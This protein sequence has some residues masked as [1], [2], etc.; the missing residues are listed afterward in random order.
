MPSTLPPAAFA[1]EDEAQL[2]NR[3][4]RTGEVTEP[5]GFHQD[6]DRIQRLSAQSAFP[7]A[8]PKAFKKTS[9]VCGLF[10]F[11]VPCSLGTNILARSAPIQ[12]TACA[13]TFISN[14][15]FKGRGEPEMFTSIFTVALAAVAIPLLSQS[16]TQEPLGTDPVVALDYGS[17]EGVSSNGISSFFGIPYAAPP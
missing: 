13:L 11:D 9:A 16:L 4:K 5:Y 12:S 2:T 14:L 7:G 8:G 6:T 10:T 17:F 3:K 15:L 1:S